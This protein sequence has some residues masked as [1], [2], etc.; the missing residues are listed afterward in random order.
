MSW[1]PEDLK[2]SE[3]SNIPLASRHLINSMNAL[4]GYYQ[5]NSDD[6]TFMIPYGT[7]SQV[8]FENL[9]DVVGWIFVNTTAKIHIYFSESRKGMSSFS[10]INLDSPENLLQV[11]YNNMVIHRFHQKELYNDFDFQSEFENFKNRVKYTLYVRKDDEP[12]HRMR[13]LNEMLVQ[14]QTPIVVNHDADVFISRHAF[15]SALN[16]LRNSNT[17]CVYPYGFGKYQLQVHPR[18]ISEIVE[19]AVVTGDTS[20]LLKNAGTSSMIWDAKYGHTIFYKKDSYI[21]MF[22]ENEEFVSWAPEDIERY[23]RA[24]K[25]GL[26]IARIPQFV[27][28]LEHPR[29][30][31]SSNTNPMFIKNEMLWDKLQKMNKEE[32]MSY[33]KNC[34]YVKR[35]GW[36]S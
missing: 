21:R 14:S 5:I 33:Y 19:E 23:V 22:G 35:Y 3:I 31:D 15:I 7:D 4:R 6:V 16:Y 10:W 36:V 11:F 13:Y 24:L 20:K 30:N 29:G 25:F 9:C 28:H 32:L 18:Q 8:R 27:Y 26:N 2:G 34:D 17:D 12:F 1:F